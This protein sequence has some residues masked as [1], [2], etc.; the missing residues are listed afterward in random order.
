MVLVLGRDNPEEVPSVSHARLGLED[1]HA[2]SMGFAVPPVR[3][4]VC[5]DPHRNVDLAFH[6]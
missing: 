5:G 2:N 6:G 1:F 4:M 3:K